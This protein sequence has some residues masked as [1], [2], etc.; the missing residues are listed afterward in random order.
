[1][2]H[3][4]QETIPA[5][6]YDHLLRSRNNRTNVRYPKVCGAEEK[7]IISLSTQGIGCFEA[8]NCVSS[9]ENT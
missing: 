2:S 8:M 3:L 7:M 4:I 5:A 1:M 9:S 6:A